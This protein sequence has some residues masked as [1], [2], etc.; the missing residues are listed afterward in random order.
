MAEKVLFGSIHGIQQASHL[1]KKLAANV[2][3]TL[4]KLQMP[5]YT[6]YLAIS[7]KESDTILDYIEAGFDLKKYLS[8]K[9]HLLR[10][11]A[12]NPHTTTTSFVELL[13]R[14]GADPLMTDY[15]PIHDFYIGN[16]ERFFLKPVINEKGENVGNYIF[17]VALANKNFVM[18]EIILRSIPK[19][20]ISEDMQNRM[21]FWLSKQGDN[22]TPEFRN[23]LIAFKKVEQ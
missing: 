1:L 8:D 11:I 13:Y 20:K 21:E 2:V 6:L 14:N 22:I 7:N 12:V 3:S 4:R 10:N 16:S 5:E 17:E 19:E 15:Q 9:P 23:F 18:A